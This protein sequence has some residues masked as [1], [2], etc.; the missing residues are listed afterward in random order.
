MSMLLIS[1]QFPW[2]LEMDCCML[3]TICLRLPH[4]IWKK[5]KVVIFITLLCY[6]TE[7]NLI[8]W[9]IYYLDEDEKVVVVN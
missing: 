1:Y 4:L 2:G 3:Y 7:H 9:S 5:K 8:H 6:F